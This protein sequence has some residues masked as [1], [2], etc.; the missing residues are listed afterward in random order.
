[1]K[2]EETAVRGGI[3]NTI[4]IPTVDLLKLNTAV[5]RLRPGLLAQCG[6]L[7]CKW[8]CLYWFSLRGIHWIANWN[9]GGGCRC[10][11]LSSGICVSLHLSAAFLGADLIFEAFLHREKMAI[12]SSRLKLTISE[13]T[14]E[15]IP[16]SVISAKFLSLTLTCL[17]HTWTKPR[18][19]GNVKDS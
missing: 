19:H 18:G 10:T 2:E 14:R 7:C 12:C 9:I 17:V 8:P 4:L 15:S 1:M 6:F 16:S 5:A 13:T 11:G 3:I